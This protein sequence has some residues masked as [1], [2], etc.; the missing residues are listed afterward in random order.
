M[1]TEIKLNKGNKTMIN[2][3]YELLFIE[4]NREKET[5]GL[6]GIHLFSTVLLF[7]TAMFGIINLLINLINN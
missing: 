6:R 5:S 7:S 2:K 4:E 3:L 1:A